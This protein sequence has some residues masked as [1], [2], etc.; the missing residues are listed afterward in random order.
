MLSRILIFTSRARFGDH[1]VCVL[2]YRTCSQFFADAAR[3]VPSHAWPLARI[4][5]ECLRFD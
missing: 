2:V 4:G 3:H 5:S 1:A